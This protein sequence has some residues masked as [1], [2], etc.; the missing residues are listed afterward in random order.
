MASADGR[1]SHVVC[2]G[3]AVN[4]AQFHRYPAGQALRNMRR[5]CDYFGVKDYEM[6][7]ARRS[8]VT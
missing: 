3:A 6:R 2:K 4:R 5:L 8:F 7:M 1:G